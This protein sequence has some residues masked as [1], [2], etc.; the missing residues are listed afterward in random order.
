MHIVGPTEATLPA[1]S[2]ITIL[3]AGGHASVVV[4]ACLRAGMSLERLLLRDAVSDMQVFG[5][6]AEVPEVTPAIMGQ[7]FHVAV[8]SAAAR[9]KLTVLAVAAGAQP[10]AVL[11]PAAI[12]AESVAIGEGAFV[13]ALAVI[14]PRAT[15]GAAT[16][17]NHGAV[18]EHDCEIGD[19]VH[20]APRATL[21]GGARVG[22][23]SLIGTGAVVLPGVTV[24]PGTTIGAGAVVTSPVSGGTWVG[25]PAR[26]MEQQ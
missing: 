9:E 8:G 16:I 11:H 3:G 23:R 19:F 5:L 10:C 21:G 15:I 6:V 24:G 7:P 22:A 17:V 2:S 18:V 20:V 4:D 12:V 13:A 14:A 25:I 1:G 26:R